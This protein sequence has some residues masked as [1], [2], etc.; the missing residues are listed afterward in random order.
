MSSIATNHKSKYVLKYVLAKYRMESLVY[1][2]M[3]AGYKS[4]VLIVMND[5]KS[6]NNKK[7]LILRFLYLKK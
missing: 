2:Y 4:Q 3:V 5:L 7:K 6:Y 1:V